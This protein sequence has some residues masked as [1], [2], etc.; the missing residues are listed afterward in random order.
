MQSLRPRIAE[1]QGR[2]G[3]SGPSSYR[4]LT[5]IEVAGYQ[6]LACHASDWIPWITPWRA[7]VLLVRCLFRGAIDG[8]GLYALFRLGLS[9]SRFS[10][11]P[12]SLLLRM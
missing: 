3:G 7:R 12:P 11:L 8:R 1:L 5:C 9:A 2:L 10:A 6:S 4:R